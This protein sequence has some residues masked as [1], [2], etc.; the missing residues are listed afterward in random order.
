MVRGNR[1]YD[2]AHGG[3]ALDKDLAHV[4]GDDT[5]GGD[6]H[7]VDEAQQDHGAEDGHKPVNVANC[8]D[9]VTLAGTGVACPLRM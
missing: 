8:F 7:G 4:H 2:V 1:E 3:P 5:P 6:D 9:E